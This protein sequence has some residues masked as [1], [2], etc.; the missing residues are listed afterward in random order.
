MNT[1]IFYIEDA[2][3]VMVIDIS[4]TCLSD[5]LKW[6]LVRKQCGQLRYLMTHTVILGQLENWIV[7]VLLA[8]RTC[9]VWCKVLIRICRSIG[10]H[11]KYSGD[12]LNAACL[13]K[14]LLCLHGY[15]PTFLVLSRYDFVESQHK[16][17]F[18]IKNTKESKRS[19][20]PF[21]SYELVTMLY[22]VVNLVTNNFVF[23]A[24][25]YL[26]KYVYR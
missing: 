7:C 17:T 24:K 1:S 4:T 8:T 5:V 13:P 14:L 11:F 12:T 22:L 20:Y 23:C 3:N 10:R 21:T 15:T 6:L 25:I 26:T 2:E 16:L 18:Y 19:K 9:N